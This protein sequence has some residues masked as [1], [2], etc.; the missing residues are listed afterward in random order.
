MQIATLIRAICAG[1]RAADAIDRSKSRRVAVGLRWIGIITLRVT[2]LFDP[3]SRKGRKRVRSSRPGA[4]TGEG[5][6]LE[7]AVAAAFR[8]LTFPF[9]RSAA[10]TSPGSSPPEP[11]SS[12]FRAS[13]LLSEPLGQT[14]TAS[15]RIGSR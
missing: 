3:F 13:S 4:R 10:R 6:T 7:A 5:Q 15:P 2:R 11:F 12:F 1:K 9:C 8:N 14:R